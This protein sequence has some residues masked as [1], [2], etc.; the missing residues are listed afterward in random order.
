MELLDTI[1]AGGIPAIWGP[2]HDAFSTNTRLSLTDVLLSLSLQALA[3]NPRAFNNGV[4]P[5]ASSHFQNALTEDRCFELLSL[6][7]FGLSKLYIILKLAVV[8][9]S[10]SD[11][12]T[13]PGDFLQKFVDQVLTRPEN[14]VRLVIV[15]NEFDESFDIEQDPWNDSQILV[16]GLGPGPLRRKGARRGFTRYSSHVSPLRSSAKG[17]INWLPTDVDI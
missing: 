10:A 11:E 12:G 15:A 1:R 13:D 17:I 3:L 5:I 14:G 7:I 2:T 8:N 6:C 16:L 4:D 9:S